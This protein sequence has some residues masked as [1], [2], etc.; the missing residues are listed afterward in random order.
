M[1]KKRILYAEDDMANRMLLEIVCKN[2]GIECDAVENGR[3]ALQK[4]Q[5]HTYDLVILDQYMPEMDGEEVAVE[6]RKLSADIPL[7][8]VTSDDSLKNRL[9]GKGFNE[10]IIKPLH[11][12]ATINIVKSYL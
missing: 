6:I 11:G 4:Y 5:E 10:V 1:S 2:E 9:L 8:A 12:D 7:I 3:L